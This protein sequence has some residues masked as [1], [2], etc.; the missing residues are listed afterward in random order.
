VSV[1]CFFAGQ[2][3]NR[4]TFDLVSG[5]GGLVWTCLAQVS[6]SRS[7]VRVQGHRRKCPLQAER[8]N[9]KTSSDNA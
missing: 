4:M 7:Q 8:E 9:Q 1:L 6:R 2:L 5:R 3:S